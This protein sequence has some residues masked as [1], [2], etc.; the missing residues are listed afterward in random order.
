LRF[1]LFPIDAREFIVAV[2]DVPDLA[3]DQ[4][5]CFADEI[6]EIIFVD[7]SGKHE[8]D[9]RAVESVGELADEVDFADFAEAVDDGVDDGIEA[10][11]FDKDV[12]DIPVEGVVR[13][14]LEVLFIPLRGGFEEAG[15]FEPVEFQAD[16]VAG[17]AEFGFQSAQVR[18]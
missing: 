1:K 11:V 4:S 13:V 9:D 10:D 6:D 12:V 17:V 16:S 2:D 14:G 8:V 3:L 7:V 15:F 18:S 5:F